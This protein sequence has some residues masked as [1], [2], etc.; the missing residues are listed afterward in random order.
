[1]SLAANI[2]DAEPTPS[3]DRC[4]TCFVLKALTSEDRQ[5]FQAAV[6]ARKSGSVLTRAIRARLSELGIEETVGE[7]SV[8]SHI[9][10]RHAVA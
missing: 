8:R 10:E 1:M 4:K 7:T 3:L 6:L 2:R 9:N 5:D